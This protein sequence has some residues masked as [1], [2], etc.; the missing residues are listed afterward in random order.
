MPDRCR[1]IEISGKP[2]ER[3]VSYGTQAAPE[4]RIGI[5]HYA[6]QV[7]A[8]SLSDAEI[9]RVAM[10]F[11][12]RI[13]EFAPHHVEEMRGVARGADVPFHHILLLNARTEILKL[14]TN[15]AQRAK[16]LSED[17]PDGCTGIVVQ[18]EA[19]AERRLIHA[20][21]WD[22]KAE[23]AESSIVV[24]IRSDDGPDILMFTEAG[25]LGRFGFNSVGTAIT[26]NYLESDRDYRM[27]GFPLALLRRHVL[28]HG[29][30][31][32]SLK[33]AYTI[34]KSTSNNMLVSTASGGLAFDLECAPDESFLV[35][36]EGGVLVHANHWRSP[37][38][39]SKLT[40][41]GVISMPDS[42]YRDRRLRSL[43]EPLIG[44][45]TVAQLKKILADNWETPWSL[46]RPPRPS[47]L[48]N[49]TATVVT[50]VM[51]PEIG[52]MEVS[53]LPA[54]GNPYHDYRLEMEPTARLHR[55]NS[56]L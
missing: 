5:A 45:I 53:L 44:S 2:Y 46:C 21:N 4:I 14:A 32:Q 38:A 52:L 41:R 37:V 56:P 17:E 22:W 30:F 42:L 18:P 10:A 24:R 36:P 11:V 20:H 48:H 35:E 29:H 28:E 25:A 12:P 51:Q 16:L 33:S 7:N 27:L 19:S 3:G 47:A 55:V 26:A 9:E 54:N 31:A 6:K 34:P 23:S 39:L 15:P 13:E 1:L 8:L 49:L 43:I 40:E 50:L